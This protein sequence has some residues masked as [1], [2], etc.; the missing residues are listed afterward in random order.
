LLSNN[1]LQDRLRL[2]AKERVGKEG[3]K[4]S[5]SKKYLNLGPVL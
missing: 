1:W 5:K 2:Q 4:Y 3:V